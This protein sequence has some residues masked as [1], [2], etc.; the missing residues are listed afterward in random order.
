MDK[1]GKGGVPKIAIETQLGFATVHVIA[2]SAATRQSVKRD[3]FAEPVLS[4]MRFFASLRMTGSEGLAMT[5]SFAGNDKE[6]LF[7]LH[8]KSQLLKLIADLK[9]GG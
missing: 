7:S 8:P 9:R 1:Q 4:A 3:C 6:T 5:R 2:R